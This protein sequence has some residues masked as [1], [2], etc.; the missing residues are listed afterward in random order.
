MAEENKV[1]EDTNLNNDNN[2]LNTLTINKEESDL[3]DENIDDDYEEIISQKEEFTKS[4]KKSPISKI[5]IGLIIFLFLLLLVGAILYFLGYFT[6]KEEIVQTPIQETIVP[7]KNNEETYKFD[8]KDI[9]SKKLNDQLSFLTNK[10]I[11]QDKNDEL[12]KAENERK[13]IEEQ[14]RREE[15][16]FKEQEDALLKEKA[17]IEE[18]KIQLE[19]EKAQLEAMRQE[20]IQL[21]VELQANKTKLESISSEN[22]KEE[23]TKE[24]L[25]EINQVNSEVKK[26]DGFLKFINV[27]KIKGS[28][29]K[30]YLD[31]ITAI[32]PNVILCRDDKNRIEIYY[33]PFNNDEIRAKLLDKLIDNNIE[34]AYAVEFTQEEFDKRCN[35]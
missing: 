29:Y 6:P 14:K 12:E 15:E 9:N 28:L 27:A 20:A 17:A 4:K 13:I 2:D 3:V 25:I 21:K 32:N 8:I 23:I 35:Y 16:A 19:N 7:N 33:G 10:N 5:L 31:K 1:G 11:N 18:K 26:A 22:V 34:E 30:K 24:A